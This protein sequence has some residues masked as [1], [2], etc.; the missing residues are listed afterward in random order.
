M[1]VVLI[2]DVKNQ[3]KK[4]AVLNV[5]EGYARN[6][7]YPQKLAVPADSKILN[8]IKNKEA[9]AAHRLAED[10]AAAEAIKARL[11]TVTVTVKVAGGDSG[12]LYGAVTSKDIADAL[13]AQHKIEVD[14]KKIV[15]SEPIKVY[16][17]YAPE[18]KL[19]QDVTAT[20][21]VAVIPA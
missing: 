7:L 17:N 3:G 15:L 9:A 19:F 21:A 8:E 2:Q 16:G 13:L 10:K 4:G 11:A 1:K 18:V 5:S 20:I 14:K 12:R 6:F